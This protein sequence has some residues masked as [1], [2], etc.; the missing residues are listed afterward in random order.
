MLGVPFTLRQSDL[1][2]IQLGS[3]AALTPQGGSSRLGQ[4][5]LSNVFVLVVVCA[6]V[7]I[8]AGP[9][10]VHSPADAGLSE[11]P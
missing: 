9:P 5:R 6:H 10:N 4:V 2:C 8:N 7:H 11:K 1:R 3:P